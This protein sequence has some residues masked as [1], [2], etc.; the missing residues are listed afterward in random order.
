MKL[1]V[2]LDRRFFE[3]KELNKELNDWNREMI[4]E[5]NCIYKRFYWFLYNKF[6]IRHNQY[7]I[8]NILS[9]RID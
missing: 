4:E 9:K 1:A 7:P 2:G 5:N 6:K 8:I 3:P